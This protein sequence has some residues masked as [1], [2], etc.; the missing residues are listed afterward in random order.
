MVSDLNAE[1]RKYGT[2][3]EGLI[4]LGVFA[5]ESD[6]EVI[7]YN[8]EH[9]VEYPSISGSA[10]GGEI[11]YETFAPFSGPL[12]IVLVAPNRT[13]VERL[14]T[15]TFV[16]EEL[17]E[18]LEQYTFQVSIKNTRKTVKEFN[19]LNTK[20]LGSGTFSINLPVSGTFCFSIISLNGKTLLKRER[21]VG[22]SGV[23]ILD[24]ERGNFPPGLYMLNADLFDKA[25]RSIFIVY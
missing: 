12:D 11:S 4:V 7:A 6:A 23:N 9:G 14:A 21:V 25:Y 19:T 2:N 1:Y 13:I 20:Y 17:S 16:K 24:T 8:E 15:G 5:S 10:G 18:M 22:N 3:K